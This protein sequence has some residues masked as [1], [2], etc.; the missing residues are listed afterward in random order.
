MKQE[1][2]QGQPT[3]DEKCDAEGCN[4]T[5]DEQ[6]MYLHARCHIRSPLWAILYQGK[7]FMVCAE[8]DAPVKTFDLTVNH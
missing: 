2:E 4:H 7:L 3:H 5:S 8:C 1:Q 6:P